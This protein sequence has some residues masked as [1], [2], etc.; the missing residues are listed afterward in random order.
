VI[1]IE[2]LIRPQRFE[3]VKAALDAAGATGMTVTEVRGMGKQ[4]GKPEYYRGEEYAVTLLSKI[5]IEVVVADAAADQLVEVIINAARTG[6]VGDGKIFM[7][8]LSDVIRIRTGER[9][10]E[11]L[12]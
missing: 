8:L 1:K 5:K 12:S 3:E 7:T 9:G 6:E 11:A 2:A 10:I 4:K